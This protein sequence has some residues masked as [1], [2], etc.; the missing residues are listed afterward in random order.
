MHLALSSR[1]CAHT[2]AV[3]TEVIHS[4]VVVVPTCGPGFD[5]WNTHKRLGMGAV[6]AILVLWG[7]RRA[8][9]GAQ[10]AASLAK[11]GSLRDQ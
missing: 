7:K 1:E 10:W 9:L 8:D 5:P 4:K 11:A 3:R 6:L 2:Q